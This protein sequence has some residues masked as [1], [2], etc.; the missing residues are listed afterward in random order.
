MSFESQQNVTIVVYH[1]TEL[2]H[3]K[4]SS[5]ERK[6]NNSESSIL[7]FIKYSYFIVKSNDTDFILSH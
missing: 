2:S 5:S 1:E 6:R 3:G 7:I 4:N